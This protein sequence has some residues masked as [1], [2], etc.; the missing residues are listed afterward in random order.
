V[1][2]AW[3]VLALPLAPLAGGPEQLGKRRAASD[4]LLGIPAACYR[5]RRLTHAPLTTDGGPD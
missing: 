1:A 2:M 4:R 3:W 5:L